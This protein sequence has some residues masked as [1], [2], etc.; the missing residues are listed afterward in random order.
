VNPTN[1][2]GFEG[3]RL[4]IRNLH[5]GGRNYDRRLKITP[6]DGAVAQ[7]LPG[8]REPLSFFYR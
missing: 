6:L 3:L 7:H 8:T 5:A 1:P 4:N 2:G